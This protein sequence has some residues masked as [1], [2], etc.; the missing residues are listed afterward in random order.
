[1]QIY[2]KAHFLKSV[3]V[4]LA[5]FAPDCICSSLSIGTSLIGAANRAQGLEEG[6][7][8]IL[9]NMMVPRGADVQRSRRRPCTGAGV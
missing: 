5:I 1:M 6:A 3:D 8:T 9:G 4:I 2:T 7:G